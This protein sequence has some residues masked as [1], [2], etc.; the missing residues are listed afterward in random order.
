[1]TATNLPILTACMLTPEETVP[2]LLFAA[3]KASQMQPGRYI[4]NKDKADKRPNQVHNSIKVNIG[5]KEA[6][7]RRQHHKPDVEHP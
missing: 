5:S 1:M 7:P 6:E 3:I 4:I 2:S